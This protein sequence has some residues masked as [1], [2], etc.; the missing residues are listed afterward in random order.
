MKWASDE[1][2]SK[3]SEKMSGCVDGYAAGGLHATHKCIY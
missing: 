3:A 1:G 2:T